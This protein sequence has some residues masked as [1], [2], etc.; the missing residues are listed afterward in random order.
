MSISGRQ[1]LFRILKTLL[2]HSTQ[3][4]SHNIKPPKDEF[5]LDEPSRLNFQIDGNSHTKFTLQ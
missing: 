1:V 4:Q 3:Q 2:P 5:K